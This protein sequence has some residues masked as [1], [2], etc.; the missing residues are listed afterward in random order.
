MSITSFINIYIA[1]C[2]IFYKDLIFL[3]L[4]KKKDLIMIKENLLAMITRKIAWK[5]NKII[6]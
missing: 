4:F 1:I 3:I 6:T 5:K 2:H